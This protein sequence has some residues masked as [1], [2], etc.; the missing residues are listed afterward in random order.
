MVIRTYRSSEII[1][2]GRPI[3][4]PSRAPEEITETV[5]ARKPMLMIRRAEV[6]AEMV[7]LPEVNRLISSEGIAW[8]RTVPK[9]I[10][11]SV[12]TR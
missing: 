1:R 2:E 12:L 10:I 9:T 5:E 4:S 8:Q 3:P 7:S 6:P 11:V